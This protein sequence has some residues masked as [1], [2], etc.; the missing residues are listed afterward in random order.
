MNT[1]T[2]KRPPRDRRIRRIKG[3]RPALYRGV[4]A[5]HLARKGIT[6]HHGWHTEKQ[7]ADNYNQAC[8]NTLP[9]AQ[10]VRESQMQRVQR[11]REQQGPQQHA[12]KWCEYACTHHDNYNKDADPY[13]SFDKVFRD[14]SPDCLVI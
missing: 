5:M 12:R 13:N 4:E 7:Y 9:P 2:H 10:P 1:L 3:K 14:I 8:C 6:K 11:Y